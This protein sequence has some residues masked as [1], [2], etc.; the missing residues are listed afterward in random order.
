MLL[1]QVYGFLKSGAIVRTVCAGVLTCPEKIW[2]AVTPLV[3][4]VMKSARP[5]LTNV[6]ATRWL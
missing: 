3:G 5:S 1:C 4:F 6:A 2:S